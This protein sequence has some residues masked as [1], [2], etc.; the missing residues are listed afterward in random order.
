VADGK[1]SRWKELRPVAAFVLVASLLSALTAGGGYHSSF[2]ACLLW[3]LLG[4]GFL[5]IF[6]LPSSLLRRMGRM[7]RAPSC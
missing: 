6:L 3:Q 2:W 1:V 4:P 5:W 7:M